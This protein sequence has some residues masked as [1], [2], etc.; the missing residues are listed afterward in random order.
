VSDHDNV[1]TFIGIPIGNAA[2]DAA[3]RLQERLR[4]DV[5]DQRL[6]RWERAANMHV[7]VH[8]LGDTPRGAVTDIAA[9]IES[10]VAGHGAFELLMASPSAFGSGQARVLVVGMG[11]GAEAMQALQTSVVEHV[12]PLGFPRDARPYHPH[13]TIGRI[14]RGKRLSMPEALRLV[15][16]HAAV[17]DGVTTRVEEV[18]LF[19]SKLSPSGAMYSRLSTIRLP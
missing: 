17:T 11:S 5:R 2:R 18:V 1:R 9:A 3:I 15:G 19:E 4:R 16:K 8:F 12:E 6:I 10:G 14:R 13:V 7:T